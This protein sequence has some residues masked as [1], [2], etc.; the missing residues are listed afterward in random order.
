MPSYGC[1]FRKSYPGRIGRNYG[2]GACLRAM[3]A[4]LR[5]LMGALRDCIMSRGRLE[6]EGD[7]SPPSTQHI[8]PP[9]AEAGP[10]KRI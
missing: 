6:A 2:I 9:V 7:C 1:S 10:A 3:V 4:I 8:A 5:L